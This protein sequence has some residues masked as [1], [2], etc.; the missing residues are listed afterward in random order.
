MGECGVPSGEVGR[1]VSERQLFWYM[2][3]V[4]IVQ[5]H[6]YII[7]ENVQ[8]QPVENLDRTQSGMYTI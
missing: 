4:R 1:I 5:L 2:Q 6:K 7:L 3:F 8:A